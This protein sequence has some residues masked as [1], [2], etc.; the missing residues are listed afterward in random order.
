MAQSHIGQ[1]LPIKNQSM[2]I[3]RN[4]VLH[5][6]YKNSL[7]GFNQ[8]NKVEPLGSTKALAFSGQR[9]L[10]SCGYGINPTVDAVTIEFWAKPNNTSQTSILIS[11]NNV[12]Y[13]RCFIGIINGK[14]DIGIQASAWNTPLGTVSATTDWAYIKLVMRGTTA[15]LYVNDVISITKTY[16]S[17]VFVSHFAIGSH[18]GT[19]D[20]PFQGKMSDLKISKNGIPIANYRLNES[21]GNIL[22]DLSPSGEDVIFSPLNWTEG[23]TIA[24]I[25]P[26]GKFQNAVAVE[27][28]TT[29]LCTTPDF[30]SGWNKSAW[31]DT[32]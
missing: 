15:T 20:Y 27:E 22:Y 13:E 4:T 5:A 17:Y 19:T 18:Q 31:V 29:N 14:W 30:A 10:L 6:S 25:R 3:G 32:M 11:S 21:T 16:S 8:G 2:P 12:S 1:I 24:T 26:D 23:K 7:N 28:A 9:I